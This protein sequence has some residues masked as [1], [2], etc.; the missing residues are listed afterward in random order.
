MKSITFLTLDEIL[1]IHEDQISRYGGTLGV[2][3]IGLL[4]SAVAMPMGQ[5]D[6]VYLH[7]DLYSMGA[8]Y[9][10]HI[11][12][13]HPF[14]DGNKRVGIVSAIVFLILNGIEVTAEETA[15]EEMVLSVARSEL[16]KKG[17]SHFFVCNTHKIDPR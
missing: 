6:G 16:E 4:Q 7:P 8:A 2:R 3:D 1:Q 13:N 10:F 17:I 14:L 12:S 15:L 5:F 11:T 9:L